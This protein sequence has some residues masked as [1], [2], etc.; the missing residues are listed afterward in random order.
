MLT[1]EDKQIIQRAA[2]AQG[3]ANSRQSALARAVLG[4]LDAPAA[5]GSE[6][7][8]KQDADASKVLAEKI[9]RIEE[10]IAAAVAAPDAGKRLDAIESALK[11]IELPDVAALEATI[12]DLTARLA[13]LEDALG[14]GPDAGAAPAQETE[15][16][17]KS[18]ARR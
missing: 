13:T 4:L 16:K 1:E 18:K 14:G 9:A 7:G 15:A 8:G 6:G 12:A 2:V 11:G 17:P 10:Q 3:V 5:G